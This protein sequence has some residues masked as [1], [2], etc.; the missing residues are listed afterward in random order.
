MIVKSNIIMQHSKLDSLYILRSERLQ[1]ANEFIEMAKATL[2]TIEIVEPFPQSPERPYSLTRNV[3]IK[4]INDFPDEILLKILSHFGPE[5]LCINIA[6]V[7]ERWSALSKDITLWKKL[8]YKCDDLSTFTSVVEVF[9]K[10]PIRN[11]LC[12]VWISQ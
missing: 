2:S 11:F 4:S 12:I 1:I 6:N 8:S 9:F 7:C 10:D 3:N 5:E